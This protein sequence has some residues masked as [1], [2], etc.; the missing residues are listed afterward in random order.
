[1]AVLQWGILG[2]GKI[3]TD[4]CLAIQTLDK[5][6]HK[7]KAVGARNAVRAGEFANNFNMDRF[8]GSYEELVRDPEVSIVYI[9][10][11]NTTH[12]DLTILALRNGKHVLCEKPA[13]LNA[14]ELE[15][16]LQAAK[17]A[18]LFFMEVSQVFL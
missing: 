13:A 2:A 14:I 18:G 7:L 4:F 8:Y 3:S 1:M 10:T 16:I 15:E 12:K 11:I 17:E 9:G 6:K 5:A